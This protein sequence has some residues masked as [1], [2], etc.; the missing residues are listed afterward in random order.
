M[1]GHHYILQSHR[2]DLYRQGKALL[3]A[4]DESA[5][6]ELFNTLEESCRYENY[7]QYIKAK[8]MDR[9]AD[10][11]LFHRSCVL[12]AVMEVDKSDATPTLSVLTPTQKLINFKKA[13]DSNSSSEFCDRLKY[14]PSEI[15]H[16]ESATVEW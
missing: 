1:D 2:Q 5:M 13:N 11:V 8:I 9:S 15:R 14:S 4:N 10:V 12:T 6:L 3:Y 7:V 16:I